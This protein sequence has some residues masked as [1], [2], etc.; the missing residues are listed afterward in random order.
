MDTA[1]PPGAPHRGWDLTVNVREESVRRRR[2]IAAAITITGAALPRVPT[3]AQEAVAAPDRFHGSTNLNRALGDL[4]ADIWQTG[5]H[6]VS[7]QSAPA[8]T[9]LMDVAKWQWAQAVHLA[10]RA[11]PTPARHEALRLQSEAARQLGMMYAD[12]SAF[13]TALRLYDQ[14]AHLAETIHDHDQAAWVRTSRAYIHLYLGHHTRT[15]DH[16]H[17]A[18]RQLDRASRQGGRAAVC[19][20]A[21]LARSYAAQGDAVRTD[22]ALR[23]AY[24]AINRYTGAGSAQSPLP[25]HPARFA[26]VKLRLAA[27]E[28]YAALGDARSH[29]SAYAAALGDPS[30]SAMHKPMLLLGWAEADQDPSRA[31]HTTLLLLDTMTSPPSPVLG[32]ARALAVRATATDPHDTTVQALRMRLAHIQKIQKATRT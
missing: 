25:H 26:W 23:C 12:R 32:R 29:Q 31:A 3:L 28:S 14:A 16:A 7:P 20:H 8:R 1:S 30:V 2:F 19:A 27:A 4:A 5:A 11:A 15:I 24:A 13:P 17:T 10:R 6:Y 21:L 18:L 9:D 22:N